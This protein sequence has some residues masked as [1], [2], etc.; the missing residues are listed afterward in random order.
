MINL[1]SLLSAKLKD[2]PVKIICL[3]IKDKFDIG[4][5][6]AFL[7]FVKEQ[8]I[9]ILHIHL[10]NIYSPTIVSLSGLFRKLKV[11]HKK[12]MTT[13]S[14]KMPQCPLSCQQEREYHLF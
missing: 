5:F 2:Y 14:L 9:D 8:N 7:N 12:L 10:A 11:T 4:G 3:N 6:K 1:K 13:S